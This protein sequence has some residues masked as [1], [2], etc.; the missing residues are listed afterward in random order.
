M[1]KNNVIIQ[2]EM[3]VKIHSAIV[4]MFQETF[5]ILYWI[6]IWSFIDPD[7]RGYA[8]RFACLLIGLLGLFVV[9]AFEPRVILRAV[10]AS[11]D[12][13]TSTAP[14]VQKVERFVDYLDRH[15]RKV[16]R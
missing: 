1:E 15:G 9:K 8:S 14:S 11:T 2:S 3:R 13:F 7:Q 6:G 10:D 5:V 16:M 4:Y 12:R